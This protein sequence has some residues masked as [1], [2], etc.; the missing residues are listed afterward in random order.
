M[1]TL[2]PS[3]DGHCL[4]WLAGS[5]AESELDIAELRAQYLAERLG[6]RGSKA[7]RT[8]PTQ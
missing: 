7:C 5:G 6:N 1:I 3:V 2:S 8:L 4:E